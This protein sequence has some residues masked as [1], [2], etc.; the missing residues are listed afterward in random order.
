MVDGGILEIVPQFFNQSSVT[1]TG[2][3]DCQ[4]LF[5]YTESLKAPKNVQPRLQAI[6][7]QNFMKLMKGISVVLL[8]F[9]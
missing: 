4:Q 2:D 7:S 6:Y 3:D 8:K 9:K 5:K 1:E